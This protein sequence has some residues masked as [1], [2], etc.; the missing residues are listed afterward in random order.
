MTVDTGEV[1][2]TSEALGKFYMPRS[3]TLR[4]VYLHDDFREGHQ[5]SIYFMTYSGRIATA[6][7]AD[8]NSPIDNYWLSDTLEVKKRVHKMYITDSLVI[9]YGSSYNWLDRKIIRMSGK[10]AEGVRWR[11]SEGY[12]VNDG[13]FTQIDGK[14][15]GFYES[16]KVGDSMFSNLFQLV[17]TS[18]GATPPLLDPERM[19]LMPGGKHVVYY[20][21]DVGRV[22]EFVYDPSGNAIWSD[23]LIRKEER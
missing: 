3:T 8:G 12:K 9:E 10:L 22:L 15:G 16:L 5:D 2:T 14:V 20:A 4:Y 6:A 17:Y 19:Y 21:K 18:V 1:L 7:S 23:K 11:A 13:Y